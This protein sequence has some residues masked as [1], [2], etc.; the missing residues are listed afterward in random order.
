LQTGQNLVSAATVEA[1]RLG[2]VEN[3][4]NLFPELIE[5]FPNSSV[6][7]LVG[8]RSRQIQNEV[9]LMSEELL[10]EAERTMSP[11]VTVTA[12]VIGEESDLV[13]DSADEDTLSSSIARMSND[14]LH[15]EIIGTYADIV[16]DCVRYKALVLDARRRMEAGEKVGGYTTWGEYADLYLKRIDE[17][18]PS[19]L[20]RLRRL[21]EG[22]N[23]DT[24]HRNKRKKFKSTYDLVEEGRERQTATEITQARDRGFEEGRAAEK[25]AQ[26][27][28]AKK[29]A[30]TPLPNS[31]MT[32]QDKDDVAKV[33]G[34]A[35]AKDV[36]AQ[37]EKIW[38]LSY[39]RGWQVG[40]QAGA[41][42]KL[43]VWDC[44]SGK[45]Y[46]AD[47]VYVGCKETMFEKTIR[48]G[49][50]F[51]NGADP[52]DSHCG[53]LETEQEFRDYAT[54]RMTDPEFRAEVEKLR[55]KHLICWCVQEGPER[56]EFCH[57]RV[58]LELANAKTLWRSRMHVSK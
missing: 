30:A 22:V 19:C 43:R 50:I 16:E 20:R 40:Y 23:P 54:K 53:S 55:G 8:S 57:A 1:I 42:P 47:A 13:S 2:A 29:A 17:S 3:A 6:F 41:V 5:E 39:D 21:L 58:W 31:V 48:E 28:L 34:L 9:T 36:T 49:T 52:L 46:P 38:L 56:A 14:E 35:S 37:L 4:P 32:L 24:K 18:L 44:N 7:P 45:Q 11:P 25:Q 51:G 15:K 27:I 33:M 12:I 26:E 10:I